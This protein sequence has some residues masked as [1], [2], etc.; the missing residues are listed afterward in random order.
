[1]NRPYF[2]RECRTPFSECYT[3]LKEGEAVGRVDI[4]F[5][6]VMAHATLHV[7]E[8]QS[9]DDISDL[10]DAVDAELLGPAVTDRH[11]VI[12][13]IHQGRDLGA[14]RPPPEYDGEGRPY[15]MS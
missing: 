3:I 11:D 2:E 4:H 10:V 15:S 1:M 9:T 13:H 7:F 6:E 12:V 5:A 14:Y 8:G